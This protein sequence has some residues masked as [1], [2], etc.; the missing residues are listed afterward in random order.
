MLCGFSVVREGGA[1]PGHLGRFVRPRRGAGPSSL[2]VVTR[3]MGV[4]NVTPDSFSDGGQWSDIGAA[5]EH[6]RKMFADGAAIVDIGGESTRPGA[7]PV[8]EAEELRRVLPVIEDLAGSGVPVSIDTR[9]AAVARAAVGAGSTI[10]NDVSATLWPIAA[11]LGVGW[12]AMHMPADPAVMQAYARYDDVVAEVSEYLVE[13]AH[14]ARSAGVSEVWVD[15]G[16]GFGKNGDHNLVLLRH[17][18]VLVGTGFPVM[19]GASRKSFLGR[20]APQP[21]GTPAPPLDRLEASI[22]V[23]AWA[24]LQGVD[25]VRVHD[26]APAVQAVRLAALTVPPGPAANSVRGPAALAGPGPG[27]GGWPAPIRP[28]PSG[29]AIVTAGRLQPTFV[30]SVR[31]GLRP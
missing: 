25:L 23:T 11:E 18:D 7:Q 28:A 13:R 24:I 26:V 3:V 15:P 17:L 9:K 19:I 6:G 16:L 29:P 31:G 10:I 21:D 2:T 12:V 30:N 1:R 5:I 8:P 14:A 20:L 4:L 27:A 22:A